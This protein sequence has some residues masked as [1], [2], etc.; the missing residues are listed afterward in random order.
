M[1]E[2]STSP[3]IL[4]KKRK[5]HAERERETLFKF[6]YCFG[7]LPTELTGHGKPTRVAYNH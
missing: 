6:K 5:K 2:E 4:K 1:K 3:L 7:R